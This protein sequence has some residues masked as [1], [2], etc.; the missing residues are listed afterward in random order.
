M[1]APE[2][3]LSHCVQSVSE[4]S[5]VFAKIAQKHDEHLLKML[6]TVSNHESSGYPT[7]L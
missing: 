6:Q 7:L 3:K 1:L 4:S 5:R 2:N